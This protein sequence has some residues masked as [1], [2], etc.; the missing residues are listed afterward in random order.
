MAFEAPPPLA[1]FVCF[2]APDGRGLRIFAGLLF[3]GVAVVFAAP[4]PEPP[5]AELVV[6]PP[7]EDVA[8]L[9]ERLC[10]ADPP[11]TASSLADAPL[12]LGVS[13]YDGP[14]VFSSLSGAT[15]SLISLRGRSSIPALPLGPAAAAA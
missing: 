6:A 4:L 5:R 13:S 12:R 10:L 8:G 2:G 9:A 3:C 14:M 7:M 11:R 15:E 1:S